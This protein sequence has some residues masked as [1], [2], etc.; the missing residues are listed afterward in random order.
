MVSNAELGPP[1][2]LQVTRKDSFVHLCI[3]SFNLAR[4]RKVALSPMWAQI[5]GSVRDSKAP[6]HCPELALERNVLW[7]SESTESLKMVLLGKGQA[8]E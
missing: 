8:T 1:I 7:T 2:L 4:C 3:H 5:S 6:Q